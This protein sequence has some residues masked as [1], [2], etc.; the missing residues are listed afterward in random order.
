MTG[1]IERIEAYLEKRAAR[2]AYV[3]EF[4]RIRDMAER[5]FIHAEVMREEIGRLLPGQVRNDMLVNVDLIH[6]KGIQ[7]RL[8][9]IALVE[10]HY[11]V[12]GRKADGND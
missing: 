9:L 6:K 4:N 5:Y 11:G 3:E 12:E 10:R 1:M 8:D 2:R 7:L